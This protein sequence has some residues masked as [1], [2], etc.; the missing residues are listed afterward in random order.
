[1]NTIV[2][3][4]NEW[5]T[6]TWGECAER[7]D[8]TFVVQI[9]N[10][11]VEL[12]YSETGRPNS[13]DQKQQ[14]DH[15]KLA[16]LSKSSLEN[17]RTELKVPLQKST[18]SEHLNI[19][20]INVAVDT[21]KMYAMRKGSSLLIYRPITSARIPLQIATAE[22]LYSLIHSLLILRNSMAYTLHN[23]LSRIDESNGVIL[24]MRPHQQ[25]QSKEQKISCK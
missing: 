6:L 10:T 11:R 21:L 7:P 15:R 23:L 1:A 8:Y 17:A 5:T 18:L 19:F 3:H 13:S 9:G 2:H 4:S 14:G 12:I 16:R 22:E 24:L 20:S 25:I